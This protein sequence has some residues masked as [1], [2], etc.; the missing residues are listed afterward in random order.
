MFK[1]NVPLTFICVSA[2]NLWKYVFCL[3][4]LIYFSMNQFRNSKHLK[5]KYHHEQD[6]NNGMS[7][8]LDSGYTEE[9]QGR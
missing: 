3:S 1:N 8:C 6:A 2:L 5:S 9:I 7:D 4:F